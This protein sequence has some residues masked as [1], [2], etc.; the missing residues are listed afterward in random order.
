ML[1][2]ITKVFGNN[3]KFLPQSPFPLKHPKK[4]HPVTLCQLNSRLLQ[5]P[6]L[7]SKGI[8]NVGGLAGLQSLSSF[9]HLLESVSPGLHSQ[10]C[11]GHCWYTHVR[12][13]EGKEPTAFSAFQCTPHP[14]SSPRIPCAPR[15]SSSVRPSQQWG[16]VLA[17][18]AF[19]PLQQ[20]WLARRQSVQCRMPCA[21]S[22]WPRHEALPGAIAFLRQPLPL[23][24]GQATSN[25]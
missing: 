19:A 25:L 7:P 12:P 18:F 14:K 10:A 3:S 1:T 11:T 16:P 9:R 15:A 20:P 8:M 4:N 23:Q 5:E 21:S 6:C 24:G 17:T 22:L 13:G 2:I